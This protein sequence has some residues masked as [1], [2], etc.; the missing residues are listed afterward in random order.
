MDHALAPRP[1][2]IARC[3]ESAFERITALGFLSPRRTVF[4]GG[5]WKVYLYTLWLL[6]R[7]YHTRFYR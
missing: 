1:R 7:G 6:M 4:L 3:Q 5:K 2:I